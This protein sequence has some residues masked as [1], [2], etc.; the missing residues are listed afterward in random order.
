MFSLV[1]DATNNIIR[2]VMAAPAATNNPQFSSH[3]ADNDGTTFVEGSEG[4]VL[5]GTTNVTL[6]T[7][8]AAS[9]RRI[10]KSIAL[11]NADT[12]AVTVNIQYFDGT[13]ARTIANVTLAVGDTWTLEGT[14]NSSG[15]MKTTGG[16]SGDVVGPASATDNAVVRFDGTTGKLVQNSAVT[17]ADTTGDITGGKYNGLTVTTTTG[18]LTITNGKT[19]AASNTLTLA[20]TDSTTMTFPSTS[21]SI[22]RTDAGQ[23]FTG[24][25]TFSSPIAVGSGG[26]GLSATP[27]NGQIDIGNGTGFTRATL[28]A[29]SGISIT[30]GAG[31]ISIAATGG[32]PGGSTTQVQYNN[33]G[34]FGGITNATTDG[35]TL[36]MTSPKI[37]TAIND[38]NANELIKFTATAS[39]VNEITVANAATGNAPT[40]S[41]TGGDTNIDITLTPKGTG[42][43]NLSAGATSTGVVTA[44]KLVPTG[45][46][47][48][49][50]GMYLPT[51]NTLAF[52]TNGSE[53]MRITSGGSVCIGR[54][55][56]LS[57]GVEKL[58]VE[59]TGS[60]PG[61]VCINAAGAS[62]EN[63]IAYNSATT[64]DN[65]FVGFYTEAS[66]TLRGS[67][68]YNRTG[69][70]TA[71]NTSSDYRLKK[72][73][74]DLPN[75]LSII[76][77]LQ[78]RQFAWKETGNVTTGFIA[79][80][81]Q[82][83]LPHAV[84]GK[85]DETKV[86]KIKVS[87]EVPATYD[88][89][90]NELT[91]AVEAVFEEREVPVYQGV[92][93]SF[94]VATLTKAIQELKAIVDAQAVRIAALETK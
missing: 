39:A 29:G 63:Y 7:A 94:L 53:R 83:V 77:Q 82:A 58:S 89:Q 71:Y 59:A 72:D 54:T 55:T 37:I 3:Y 13:N 48:A 62:A 9:T 81:L 56:T 93:T 41:A 66:P 43:V 20:G 51:T 2:A 19:L 64:G 33:A 50:N 49:G 30:N 47:T 10:V 42:I 44:T 46:V 85:K 69:G 57:G 28:T 1:L 23:T 31:S 18:T 70:L 15:E 84:N 88:E 17:V 80:E 24:T 4:G 8:P 68:T 27:T 74:V 60:S 67:I 26:T 14:F 91:P 65:A 92:D 76:S 12:A 34:S 87:L 35:T 21:A 16:G 86:E 40:I 11:Y 38:T 6:V 75:A 52:G 79:H 73:I 78:P 36:S 45:N 25:Q 61:F 90:G 22:A 32:S 5:N